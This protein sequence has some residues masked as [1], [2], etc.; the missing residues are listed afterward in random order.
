MFAA[1]KMKNLNGPDRVGDKDVDRWTSYK[2]IKI[3]TN[4]T[5]CQTQRIFFVG[6]NIY[7]FRLIRCP[8]S[9]CTHKQVK[10]NIFCVLTAY[11]L[12]STL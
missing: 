2:F 3:K 6:I 9:G 1:F 10:V 7:M 8:L 4:L 12:D 5:I 11:K